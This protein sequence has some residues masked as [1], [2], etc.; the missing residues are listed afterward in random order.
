WPATAVSCGFSFDPCT[1]TAPRM[2]R[3]VATATTHARVRIGNLL[4][5]EAH[6]TR[7]DKERKSSEV[8]VFST[9]LCRCRRALSEIRL[10]IERELHQRMA[11]LQIELRADEVRTA[12]QPCAD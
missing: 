7:R 10:A 11:A 6:D 8:R 3:I 9:Y 4:C 5:F 12:G 1:A 2:E